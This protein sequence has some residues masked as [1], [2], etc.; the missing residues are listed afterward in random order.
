MCSA[1]DRTG[2]VMIIKT[3]QDFRDFFSVYGA[4]IVRRISP[5][6]N[7]LAEFINVTIT[8]L[9]IGFILTGIA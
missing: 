6:P 2:W 1:V 8:M 9:R 4:G 5:I 3:R 7:L